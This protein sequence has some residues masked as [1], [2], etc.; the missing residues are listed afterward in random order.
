[1]NRFTIAYQHD[2]LSR[3][4]NSVRVSARRS[5]GSLAAVAKAIGMTPQALYQDLNAPARL[6]TDKILSLWRYLQMPID[7]LP[8]TL[9]SI[10]TAT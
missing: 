2:E 6:T 7:S 1:M 9:R 10:L 3:F 5:A 4:A 8:A